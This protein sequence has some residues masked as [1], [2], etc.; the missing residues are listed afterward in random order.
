GADVV[1][2]PCRPGILAAA[3]RT[4]ADMHHVL[5]RPPHDAL[6]SGIGAAADRHHAGDR[7]DVGLHAAVGLALL[8]RAEVLGA[9]LGELVRIGRQDLLD[10]G[11]VARFDVFQVF[12]SCQTHV[13]ALI[14]SHR[15]GRAG[16]RN[17]NRP[18]SGQCSPHAAARSAASSAAL[19]P[20]KLSSTAFM[21]P[22]S[23]SM[24][25]SSSMVIGVGMMP[26]PPLASIF[27]ASER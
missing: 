18:P 26:L 17:G 3:D 8:E 27:R 25:S 21:I 1:V 11:L 24:S 20:T 23:M 9:P 13:L 15:P 14:A 16:S 22:C 7:L 2:P 19:L 6:R 4:M 10:E 5:D 12:S